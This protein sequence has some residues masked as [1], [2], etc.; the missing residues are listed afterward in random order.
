MK[1]TT[2]GRETK[3]WIATV[4]DQSECRVWG[5]TGAERLLRMLSA[6][7]VPKERV[8]V[9]PLKAM[10]Q[11]GGDT[12]IIFRADYVFDERLVRAL[13]ESPGT[14]LLAP[15]DSSSRGRVTAIHAPRAALAET[16]QLLSGERRLNG[17]GPRVGLGLS[18][19][20][21]PE[22]VPAYTSTLRKAAAPYLLPLTPATVGE[23]EAH[24]FAA[25]YKGVTDLVTKW[26]WPRPARIVTRWCVS[27][28]IRPNLV[29][30][31]SWGLVVL[32]AVFF[33]RGWFGP[34]LFVAWLMTFL[35]TVDGKLA[36]VTL[37]SSKI[38]HVLDHGLDIIHPPFWYLAWAYGLPQD[39]PG[40]WLATAL[41]VGGYVVGR[42][43]EGLFL[44]IFKMEIHCWRPLDSFF[45]TITAR[46]NPN[47]VLLSLATLTGRPDVGLVLVAVWTAASIGFHTV[48]LLQALFW[49]RR[50]SP[51]REWQGVQAEREKG[52]G[53]NNH[54]PDRSESLA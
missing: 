18:T 43:L 45:R 48:R 40:L 7:G 46:R 39:T 5:L 21:P 11:E 2:G 14:V 37:T 13:L 51:I 16:L 49:R 53:P 34:G 6:V 17:N 26:V 25:S 31:F 15:A 47:L 29:T 42:L 22:L 19:V 12:V 27:A 33:L 20:T 28:G 24:L 23:I 52:R 3:V 50:G 32:A 54:V 4:P 9:G 36:R 44:L 1:H 41:T 10:S 38:G 30:L 35:D 8:G